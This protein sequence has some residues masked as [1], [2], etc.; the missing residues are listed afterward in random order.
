MPTKG[1]MFG[2]KKRYCKPRGR[3]ASKTNAQLQ[4]S[5]LDTAGSEAATTQPASAAERKISLTAVTNADNTNKRLPEDFIYVMMN[6]MQLTTMVS[7]LCCPHCFDNK[8][9]MCITQSKGMA[10][11][12]KI[13]CL[14]CETYLWSDWTSKKSND[15]HLDINVRA[16]AALK[17]SGISHS[18]FDRFCG[19]MSKPC[20]HR[21]TYN[22]LANI[23]NTAIIEAGEECMIRAS[24]VVHGR[25]IS[26]PLTTDERISST[27]CPVITV[28]FDGT[29]HK[30]GHS[31]HSGIGTVIDF[32]TGLVIDTEV[33]SN[34]CHVCDSNSA[35][36]NFD[37]SKH[38]CQKNFS[39]SANAME[40]ASASKIFSR[41]VASRKLVYGTMLCDGDSKSHSSAITNSG[42]DVEILKE[43]CINH[44]SKR[45]FNALNNLKMSNKK[46]LNYRLTK[47][48]IEKIT[49]YYSKALRQN[50]PDIQKMKLAVMG[51][52]FHMM[53]SDL[54]HNHRLCPDGATSWCHFKRS[55]AL[56]QPYKKHNQTITSEIGKL[57]FPIIKR[58]TDTDLLKRCSRMGTQNANESFHSLIWQRCPKTEF[59]TLKTVRAATYLAVLAFN[60]GPVG[61]R[62]VFDILGIPWTLKNISSSEKKQNVKL[63]LVRKRKSIALVSRRKNL[64]KR[65][66]EHEHRAEVL[67][68]PT[69]QS[70]HFNE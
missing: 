43:D 37:A 2:K 28:S 68:G 61:I 67:E 1:Y 62:S 48:K 46:E 10:H 9:T 5:V 44:I 54:D 53:S 13:K 22:N 60:N 12:I 17:E 42:Y 30:R 11:L 64:K 38:M 36:L 65:R 7:L 19:L 32:D 35:E 58:L 31:S 8:L 51:S 50:A 3:H 56:K 59:A 45:M 18:K 49:N 20:M 55:E 21:N 69:Y 66:I 16:V 14:N 39:G 23:V 25:N 40:A 41:S 15:V 33:L 34:Y 52:F 26:Q 63:Q 70:G 4:S 29:W 27:G 47:P 57:L 24:A 6:S